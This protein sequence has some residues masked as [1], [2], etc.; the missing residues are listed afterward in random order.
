M[1]IEREKPVRTHITKSSIAQPSE[2]NNRDGE[3]LFVQLRF[4]TDN[5]DQNHNTNTEAQV[6]CRGRVTWCAEWEMR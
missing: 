4:L 3:T 2:W 6:Y 1:L 5:E